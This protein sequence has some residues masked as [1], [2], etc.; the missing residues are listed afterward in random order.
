MTVFTIRYT[1]RAPKTEVL[2]P[3]GT[4]TPHEFLQNIKVSGGR[5]RFINEQNTGQKTLLITPDQ[6]QITIDYVFDSTQT[7]HYTEEIFVNRRT[8][9]SDPA[10]ELV[11]ETKAIT[12]QLTGLERAIAIACST[13]ERFTYGHP[14]ETFNQGLDH[15]PALGC[16]VAEGSCVD[17]NTYFIAALRSVGIEAGYMTGFFFPDE[18]K[19]HC[20]D[21]HCWVVTRHPTP[22]GKQTF[23]WDIAHH[24]KLGTRDIRPGLNPKP[25]FRA[26]TYHSMG[27]SFPELG[28]SNHKALIEPRYIEGGK[29]K[30]F[31]EPQIELFHP[32]VKPL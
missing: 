12:P 15:V 28:I 26:A 2:A 25:G 29:L 11:A 24:L 8:P 6:E 20:N 21:G 19:T 7:G 32:T 18:K 10:E 27:L 3:G 4:T 31:V 13:A 22:T 1:C 23:E 5:S 16:G 17:I 30:S 9:F 14:K